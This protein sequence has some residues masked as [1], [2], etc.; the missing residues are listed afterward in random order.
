[1][2]FRIALLFT[3]CF[4]CTSS[5][6][7]AK[8]KP[9][10]KSEAKK[11]SYPAVL[12]MEMEKLDGTKI[13]LG[14]EFKDKVVLFVNV[15]SKCGKTPQYKP[16]QALHTKYAKKGLVIVG[17]PCNQFGGQESG[18]AK[19]I[20]EFCTENYGIE[21]IMMA[22]VDVNGSGACDLY[23]FLTSKEKNSKFGGKIRWNFEKFLVSRDGV[24][25]ERFSPN[26]NPSA[27]EVLTAIKREISKKPAGKK[28]AAK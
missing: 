6:S 26:V 22:K 13:H 14:K 25:V 24:C 28:A 10:K 8:D 4:V 12:D 23:K 1:M 18:S 17:V 2:I 9:A 16:L 5:V 27:K 19:E 20:Q 15:A 3:L 21:F 11:V 7:Q